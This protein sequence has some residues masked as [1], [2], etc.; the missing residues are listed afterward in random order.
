LSITDGLGHRPVLTS[1]LDDAIVVTDEL[2]GLRVLGHGASDA[3]AVEQAA[4]ELVQV[5]HKSTFSRNPARTSP[6]CPSS[7]PSGVM[8]EMDAALMPILCSSLV[9]HSE[10]LSPA[11]L[12]NGKREKEM[13]SEQRKSC[14][15]VFLTCHSPRGSETV[16]TVMHACEVCVVRSCHMSSWMPTCALPLY[17]NS[18]LCVRTVG[19][20]VLGVYVGGEA[21]GHR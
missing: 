2:L 9:N 8:P 15:C 21:L 19:A 14:G 20:G 1:K 10:M 17:F 12:P 7:A 18:S 16:V 13:I 6:A 5:A 3:D 4:L 11:L